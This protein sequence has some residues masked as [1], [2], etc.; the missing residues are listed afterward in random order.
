MLGDKFSL[1]VL[2]RCYYRK[3]FKHHFLL[4]LLLL[5]I[6]IIIKRRENKNKIKNKIKIPAC[7]KPKTHTLRKQIVAE[8][9]NAWSRQTTPINQKRSIRNVS[10]YLSSSSLASFLSQTSNLVHRSLHLS[11]WSP[12]FTSRDLYLRC[13]AV[14]SRAKLSCYFGPPKINGSNSKSISALIKKK[15]KKKKKKIT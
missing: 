11:T 9:L 8:Y 14:A 6:I 5:I 1:S 2:I 12:W 4:L 15:K 10:F 7:G 3:Y 13:R